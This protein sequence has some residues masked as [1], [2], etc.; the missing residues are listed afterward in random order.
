MN[1]TR[2]HLIAGA[3][4]CLIAP[5]LPGRAGAQAFPFR[6]NQRY[7]DPAVQILDPSFAKY[8]I[9][10]STLE[11]VATGMRWAE[12]PVY[13]P[14]GGY[15]LCSDVPNNRIMKYDERDGSFTVFRAP[16]NFAN[17]NTRDRQGRLITCEHSVT[18]RVTRTE[19]D[20]AITVLA[21][22][23]EGKRLNSPND[24]VVR[25]DGSIWFTD[26][27]FGINGEWEGD[28]AKS[29]QGA[30]HVFRIAP[31]GTL[32]AV[33][34]D[35]VN[36]NG[37][38]FSPDESKLYVVEWKGTPNRSMWSYPVRPDG[39]LGARTKLIDA[40]DQGALDGFRVDRDGNLWCGWGSNGALREEPE[41][42]DGRAVYPLKGRPEDLDGVK[43][44]NPEGKPIGFI[45]LPER[46]ANL[47]FGGP[48]RN[49][50]YMASSHS[51]YA[52]Y[53]EAHGAV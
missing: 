40:S 14:D 24:V 31:D 23:F 47:A 45:R 48:K 2:R 26:P 29:E 8:R 37:L 5:A 49:R 41:T 7:P 17:G 20:G 28:R 33:I 16:A 36:P 30:T 43:V 44:F 39:S 15:L 3:G 11:Q 13:F 6:P 50:L 53:V 34:S 1:P 35:I 22:G 12:G 46:C 32:S 18:R 52:L 25:S 10:S 19:G 4:A 42:V 21:D 27:L 38:A 51:L 9:Y